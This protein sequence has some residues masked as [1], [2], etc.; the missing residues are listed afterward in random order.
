MWYKGDDNPDGSNTKYQ[1]SVDSEAVMYER[2]IDVNPTL[3]PLNPNTSIQ[4]GYYVDDNQDA[5]IGKPLFFY[6]IHQAAGVSTDS[7]SLLDGTN[8]IEIDN[9]FIPSNS[10][11]LDVTVANDQ[12]NINFYPET[13]EYTTSSGFVKTLFEENYQT[14][15]QDIFNGKRR[16]TRIKAWLPLKIIYNL[17]MNDTLTINNQNYKINTIKTNLITGESNIELLNEL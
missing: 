7:V 15:I 6:A 9:Y 13:N 3:S 11:G 1:I 14:Y 5:Y 8:S 10:L 16:I 12:K 4:Y 2:L 17:N